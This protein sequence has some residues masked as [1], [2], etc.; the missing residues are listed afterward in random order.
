MPTMWGIKYQNIRSWY[1][2]PEDSKLRLYG[3]IGFLSTNT[4]NK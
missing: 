4:V 2:N 1:V 3:K